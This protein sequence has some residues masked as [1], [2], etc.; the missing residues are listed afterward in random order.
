MQFIIG[1]TLSRR[2]DISISHAAG[3]AAYG[4]AAFGPG[5]LAATAAF[6]TSMAYVLTSLI[7]ATASAF[8]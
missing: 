8:C 4:V 2:V 3:A 6:N 7:F 1:A 5:V